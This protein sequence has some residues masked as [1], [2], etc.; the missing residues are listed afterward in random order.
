M[1][2]LA[3]LLR[4]VSGRGEMSDLERLVALEE[5]KCLKA[6]RD[7]TLDTKD[8]V[9]FRALHAPDACV[10]GDQPESWK[11]ADEI[12]ARL[13]VIMEGVTSVHH[14]HTP[15]I[16]FESRDKAAGIWPMEDSNYWKQGDEE[17]WQHGAGF[18]H[19]N[20][21]KRDGKWLYTRRQLKR[22]RMETSPGAAPGGMPKHTGGGQ[23]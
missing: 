21:E 17:H 8:W 15:I 12:T 22:T 23:P 5:I 3:R 1:A 14:C 19:E 9:G 6:K 18:Y 20:Y 11:S 2:L 10:V 16:T 13:K 4:L 7:Y